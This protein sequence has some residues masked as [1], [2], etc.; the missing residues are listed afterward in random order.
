MYTELSVTLC[1]LSPH[2]LHP[3]LQEILS[4]PTSKYVW[5]PLTSPSSM[6]TPWSCP[7]S[8]VFTWTSA[9]ASPS[10]CS[11]T[12][13]P[14]LFLT[15]NQKEPC[16]FTRPKAGQGPGRHGGALCCSLSLAEALCGPSLQTGHRLFSVDSILHLAPEARL[17]PLSLGGGVGSV[18][19]PHPESLGRGEGRVVQAG[20]S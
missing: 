10:L 17:C 15:R 13:H 8:P 11:S 2:T 16:R 18:Q 1:P 14:T 9:A 7:P 12:H 20:H 5:D 19:A 3:V 6:G 4:V